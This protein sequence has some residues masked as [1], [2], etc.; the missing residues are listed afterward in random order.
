M[1]LIG[2]DTQQAYKKIREMIVKLEL[3]P[4]TVIDEVSLAEKLDLG[5]V[6]VREALKLLVHDTFVEIKKHQGIYI[7][8]IKIEDLELLSEVRL[9]MEGYAARLAAERATEDDVTIMEALID[10]QKNIPEDDKNA[11][12]VIDHKFHQAI[13][14]AAH[15]HYLRD[16]LEY[17]F[18]LSQRLWYLVLPKLDFLSLSVQEHVE[19]VRAIEKH[20][21]SVAEKIMTSHIQSFYNKVHQIINPGN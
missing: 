2:V 6:P 7:S 16:S 5:Q 3:E 21:P 14:T 15:N 11:W 4:G 19:L 17:Y 1:Q 10:E 9:L 8:E 13:A 12:F 20:N 18:G